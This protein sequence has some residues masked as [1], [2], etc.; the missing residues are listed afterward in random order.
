MI[1]RRSL[2]ERCQ[3]SSG[4]PEWLIVSEHLKTQTCPPPQPSYQSSTRKTQQK[5]QKQRVSYSPESD[6]LVQPWKSVFTAFLLQEGSLALDSFQGFCG[7][8]GTAVCLLNARL[9]EAIPWIAVRRVS[10]MINTK[11]TSKRG[12][13]LSEHVSSGSRLGSSEISK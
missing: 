5:K 10:L 7:L 12:L 13:Q 2:Y 8:Q 3:G 4:L 9:L 1:N 6:E 11:I